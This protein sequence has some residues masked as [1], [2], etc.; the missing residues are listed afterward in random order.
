MRPC[1]GQAGDSARAAEA[2][3]GEP[4]DVCAKREGVCEVRV[5]R[6]GRE[7]PVVLTKTIASKDSGRNRASSQMRV[8]S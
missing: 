7:A 4:A 2:P 1:V 5:D 6:G 8:M 3:D